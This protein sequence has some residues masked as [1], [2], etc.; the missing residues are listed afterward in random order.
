MAKKEIAVVG[1]GLAGLTASV[2]LARAGCSVTLFERSSVL[3][4]RGATKDVG[5]FRFN[6]GPHSF[7]L[8]ENVKSVLEN[9]GVNYTG[10]TPDRS[11]Q[12]MELKGKL[13]KLPNTVPFILHNEVLEEDAKKEILNLLSGV[14]QTDTAKWRGKSVAE[15]MEDCS[16]SH[17]DT[18][19]FV[20]GALRLL[21]YSSAADLF[22]AE[23]FL[24]LLRTMPEV[25]YLD[26]GWGTL[27]SGLEQAAREAGVR[28]AL[29]SKVNR[30]HETAHGYSLLLSEGSPHPV[31]FVILAV[32]PAAVLNL[33]EETDFP[34]LRNW[35]T[36][37][38]PI[39]A[40]A[41]NVALRH[42]PNPEQPFVLG[43]DTPYYY[44]AHSDAARLAPDEGAVVHLM[45]YVRPGE[46]IHHAAVREELR[47]WMDSLQ[48]GWRDLIVEEQFLPS[49]MVAG[50]IIQ[51]KRGGLAGRFGP[52]VPGT[53]HLYVAG[54][55]VG[56]EAQLA[57][58]SIMS[59]CRAASMILEGGEL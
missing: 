30:I 14:Q 55:W 59:A 52:Q 17:P 2:L 58:A 44:S 26:D 19:L 12:L 57:N 5:G 6:L 28:I 38:I 29:S 45:K 27:I 53:P 21:T 48:P 13:G 15:W 22:D 35:A 25:W 11:K 4:G 24:S 39:Y 8:E 46:T 40:S 43:F 3:G 50:D 23:L 18:R 37:T 16:I 34:E 47:T 10:R 9:I 32:P 31:S 33:L 51:A 7:Y 49:M 56:N 1:G 42:L 54:D 36:E 41:L 20:E